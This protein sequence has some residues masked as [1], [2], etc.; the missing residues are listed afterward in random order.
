MDFDLRAEVTRRIAD[1]EHRREERRARMDAMRQIRRERRARLVL[2]EGTRP[3]VEDPGVF[4]I[5]ADHGQV[6]ETVNDDEIL[7]VL[8]QFGDS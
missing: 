4:A 3:S 8:A 6:A 2:D 1:L 7:A 5:L